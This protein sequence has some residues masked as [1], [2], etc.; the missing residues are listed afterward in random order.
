MRPPFFCAVTDRRRLLPGASTADQCSALVE[1]VALLAEAGV[2]LVHLR[3]R[4]LESGELLRLAERCVAAIG[5]RQARLLV[6]DRTDIALAA[7]AGG[8]HLRGDSIP[9]SRARELLPPGCLVGRSVHGVAESVSIAREGGVDYLV[10]GTIFETPSKPGAGGPVGLAELTRASIAVQVPVLAIGGVTEDRLDA[11]ASTGASG[12]AAIGLF[13]EAGPSAHVASGTRRVIEKG[14][15][16]F[17][18][19]ERVPRE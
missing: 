16:L 18:T 12:F 4:D 7:G 1:R 11:V 10:L 14:R 5:G 8:V 3:E 19:A 6:N 13:F 17:D 15:A 2:N 9:A